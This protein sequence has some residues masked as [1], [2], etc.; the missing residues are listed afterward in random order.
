MPRAQSRRPPRRPAPAKLRGKVEL[1]KFDR[2][3]ATGVLG[4][5]AMGTVYR[6]W[7]PRLKREVAIK[8]IK[9][10]LLRLVPNLR[11]R[12]ER[13]AQ[14]IA[15]LVHP[16]IVQ[17]FDFGGDYLVMELLQGEEL[18]RLLRAGRRFS[19]PEIAALLEPLADALDYAHATGIV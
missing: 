13:E 14:A 3:E 11:T 6:G 7:D 18:R 1:P 5:G 12:F 10:D 8:T 2:Y 4:E 17:I 15:K 9:P 19:L 16:A